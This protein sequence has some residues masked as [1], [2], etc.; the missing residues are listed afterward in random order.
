MCLR[1][2]VHAAVV[3]G[4]GGVL[5]VVLNE[6]PVAIVGSRAFHF[7]NLNPTAANTRKIRVAENGGKR[8][9]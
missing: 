6:E 9:G 2:V 8:N 1:M 3:G 4:H 5:N 7:I